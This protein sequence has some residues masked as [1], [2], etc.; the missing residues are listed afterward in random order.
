MLGAEGSRQKFVS[1]EHD[2]PTPVDFYFYFFVPIDN[3]PAA[4][5]LS[6]QTWLQRPEAVGARL[7][8]NK[9]KA[10]MHLLVSFR[11]PEV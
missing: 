9:T 5:S 11:A 1:I 6:L 4:G 8:L 10:G 7:P 3:C 2:L